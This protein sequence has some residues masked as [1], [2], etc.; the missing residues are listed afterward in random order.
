MRNMVSILCIRKMKFTTVNL[1]QPSVKIKKLCVS[2]VYA[3]SHHSRL[4]QALRLPLL[5][6]YDLQTEGN[7]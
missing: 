1:Q 3:F 5:S 6:L 4:N 2:K 7:V